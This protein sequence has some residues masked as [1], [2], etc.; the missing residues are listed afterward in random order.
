MNYA[1][2]HIWDIT[3]P[4]YTGMPVYPGD[5]PVSLEPVASLEQGQ[6]CNLRG[7]TLGSHTGTHV[8]AP[9]HFLAAGATVDELDWAALLGPARLVEVPEGL[10]LDKAWVASL[11]LGGVRRLLVRTLP[12]GAPLPGDYGG[13][14][15]TLTPEAAQRLAEAGLLLLG[16]DT[17]SVDVLGTRENSL[18]HILLGA[19]MVLLENL[20]LREPPPGDY[21]L[22]CL[23]LRIRD[24]DGSP[25]RALLASRV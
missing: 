1:E 3:L 7:L 20:D 24:G 21:D 15:P 13:G 10:R 25:C 9:R 23:P 22:L 5:P 8:D 12:P 17:P 18:H 4:L 11:D 19:G 14:W 2:R 16:L 6:A